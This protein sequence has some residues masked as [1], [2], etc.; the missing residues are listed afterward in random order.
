MREIDLDNIKSTDLI[1]HAAIS[2]SFK[3]YLIETLKYT[4][5]EA[6]FVIKSDFENPYDT[7]FIM[8]DYEG[9][10]TVDGRDY[11]VR[12]CYTDFSACGLFHLA[13]VPPFEFYMLF[14]METLPDTTVGAYQTATKLYLI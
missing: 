5:D 11:E 12:F 4:D 3:N 1:D 14:D 10:F 7:P 2:K 6:D 9:E 13:E 8:Q